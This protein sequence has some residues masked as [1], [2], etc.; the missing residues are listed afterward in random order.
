M[1]GTEWSLI[2][3][4]EASRIERDHDPLLVVKSDRE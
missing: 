4:H 3:P 2:G 1:N